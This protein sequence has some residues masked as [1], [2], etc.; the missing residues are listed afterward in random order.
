MMNANFALQW[1]DFLG[2][3]VYNNGEQIFRY[4]GQP[5]YDISPL[6]CG[7]NIGTELGIKDDEENLI[8]I[9]FQEFERLGYVVVTGTDIVWRPR[10]RCYYKIK[11]REKNTVGISQ[12]SFRNMQIQH[13]PEKR[14]V[15]LIGENVLPD[16]TL[17]IN[18]GLGPWV[19]YD[20][21]MPIRPMRYGNTIRGMTKE[22]SR[23]ALNKW[24]HGE[25]S[26]KAEYQQIN[27]I[28][29]LL[30]DEKYVVCV[31]KAR[32]CQRFIIVGESGMGK[33]VL[34]NG[35]SGRI[36]Y[37]WE[38]RVGWLID[39]LNQFC[40]LS[41]PQNYSAFNELNSFIGNE[42]KP[43]PAIQ[44][45]LACKNRNVIKHKEISLL[46]TLN[47]MEFLR[48]Y[49][50]FTHGIKEMDVGD[51]IRYLNDYLHEIKDVTTGK[52]VR[53]TM[54]K[55]IDNAHKDKGMQA[56]I[57]KWA[58]TF[59]T[60]LKEK[61]TSNIY[62][63]EPVACDELEVHL[64]NEEVLKGNPFIMCME[65]GLVPVLN[66]SAARRQ[67]WV[68]NFLADLM[69]KIVA[70][71]S[72][73]DEYL[74]KRFW[75]VADELNEI[76]EVGK[77]KDNAFAAFEELYRQG[78]FNNLGFIGNTQSLEKL[79]PEM[80]KNATHIC[81]VYMKDHKERKRVGD[82]Y[83]L[84]KETYNKIEELKEREMMIFSKEPFV[85]YD[86]WGRRKIAKDRKWFK[87]KIFPP[88]NMHKVP[89]G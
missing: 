76:Y 9:S 71:Q 62:K 89:G 17:P 70:Y 55:K 31:R 58:N 85:I 60:I 25:H 51:T 69:Q 2:N 65:A 84:D 7:I 52:E 4:H 19:V 54:M 14:R 18:S 42:P 75:I 46:V 1:L 88:I 43:I 10:Q 61:F 68:R 29:V 22:Q 50:F 20:E 49:K 21:D 77:K 5:T 72:N 15:R 11:K 41:Y 16:K 45:Y 47:W 87:G 35:L 38:D 74:R 13:D 36:F 44:L 48:K 53:D 8:R 73:R 34:C 3:K 39:P 32:T 40:D 67:K 83:A 80:Y 82:T 64:K 79:N 37:T 28:P 30:S 66:I 23:A 81:C 86:R 12:T 59:E 24:M 26:V 6:T 57:Y 33:S 63:N 56:M 78:R 27:E